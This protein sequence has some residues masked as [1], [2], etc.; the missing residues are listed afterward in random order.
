MPIR[1]PDL[2][3]ALIRL[4]S[5]STAERIYGQLRLSIIPFEQFSQYLPKSGSILDMGCGFGYVANYLSLENGAA[6]D[7][8]VVGI[9]PSDSRIRAAR[10]TI[11]GRR[12]LEFLAVDSRELPRTNF[13]GAVIADVLHHTPHDQHEPILAD[14]YAKLRPGGTLVMRETAKKWGFRYLVFNYLLEL[15]LYYGHEKA[16]FRRTS[17]WKTLLEKVGFR[18]ADV[19]PNP[20]LFPYMTSL[21]VC[22][23]P[24]GP[25]RQT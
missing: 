4:Y 9:D 22:V 24:D 1:R 20:P 6:G 15:L 3:E 5:Q 19:I 18:V 7:R 2:R 8:Y 10:R 12:N 21:F 13:A 23:K 16:N 25:H 14:V 17:E 11:G